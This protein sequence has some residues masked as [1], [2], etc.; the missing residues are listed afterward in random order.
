MS[1]FGVIIGVC[2]AFNAEILA[3]L[4]IHSPTHLKHRL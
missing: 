1:L 4:V 2:L 3:L